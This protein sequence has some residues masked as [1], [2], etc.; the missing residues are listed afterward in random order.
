M[1]NERPGLCDD[2]RLLYSGIDDTERRYTAGTLVTHGSHHLADTDVQ[3]E[4]EKGEVTST[5][6][7]R[8]AGTSHL[9]QG[10]NT[11]DLPLKNGVPVQPDEDE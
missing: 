4:T 2:P 11:N 6:E 9:T 8:N 3:P 1:A 7:A 5:S 10:P